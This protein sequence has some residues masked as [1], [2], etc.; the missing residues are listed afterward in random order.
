[1]QNFIFN[2]DEIIFND[3]LVEFSIS[4]LLNQTNGTDTTTNDIRNLFITMGTLSFSTTILYMSFVIAKTLYTFPWNTLISF[5]LSKK[6][7]NEPITLKQLWLEIK[8][9]C[10]LISHPI[11]RIFFSFQFCELMFDTASFFVFSDYEHNW[12]IC[13]YQYFMIQF[14]DLASNIWVFII[15]IWLFCIFVFKIKKFM[16]LELI[17]HWIVLLVSLVFTIIPIAT[18]SVGPAGGYC[19]I[20]GDGFHIHLRFTYYG[21]VFFI[22]FC[23]VILYIICAIVMVRKQC[24]IY[25]QTGRKRRITDLSSSVQLHSKIFVFPLIFIITYLVA[26]VRRIMQASGADPHSAAFYMFL[27]LNA[28]F[29]FSLGFF[30]TLLLVIGDLISFCVESFRRR[31]ISNILN[32]Q[33]I[34]DELEGVDYEIWEIDND[35]DDNTEFLHQQP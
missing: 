5:C 3:N 31:D 21:P 28:F 24:Y 19:W 29:E 34:T 4:Q 23:M 13:Y 2:E 15:S 30:V 25:R 16:V 27:Y 8:S 10:F 22:L 7:I 32:I 9:K 20:I 18:K 35:D 33:T 1:M 14:F 11:A 12:S 17:S 6:N 26:L